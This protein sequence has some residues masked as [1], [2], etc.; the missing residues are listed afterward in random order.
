MFQFSLHHYL[1]FGRSATMIN[2]WSCELQLDDHVSVVVPW[3]SS[4]HVGEAFSE[5]V[6]NT[7]PKQFPKDQVFLQVT[8]VA[9]GEFRETNHGI[10]SLSVWNIESERRLHPNEEWVVAEW[11]MDGALPLGKGKS[12]RA[13]LAAK[14]TSKSITQLSVRTERIPF[15]VMIDQRMYGPVKSFAVTRM[16]DPRDPGTQMQLRFATFCPPL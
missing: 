3:I 2:V 7:P 5:A 8:E 11:T 14:L 13:Q 16:D 10:R 4:L 15:Q 9:T 12:T 6:T 1:T